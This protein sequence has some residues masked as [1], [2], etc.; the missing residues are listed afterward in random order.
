MSKN[1]ILYPA[2]VIG[3]AIGNIK[4]AGN[5][6][7]IGMIA[8]GTVC[9]AG[10]VMAPHLLALNGLVAFVGSIGR[11]A[12]NQ[13]DAATNTVRTDEGA[14]LKT[15]NKMSMAQFASRC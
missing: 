5:L 13:Y 10:L 1:A 11:A 9:A 4:D 14:V 6:S 7:G 15:G 8:T 3:D 2:S 12:G